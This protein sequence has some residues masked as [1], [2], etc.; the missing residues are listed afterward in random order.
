MVSKTFENVGSDRPKLEQLRPLDSITS[1]DVQVR[2]AL[3]LI[4]FQFIMKNLLKMITVNYRTVIARE[5]SFALANSDFPIHG[6]ISMIVA[7][8]GC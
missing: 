8:N 6:T 4:E 2:Q 3:A 1:S 7:I 5:P